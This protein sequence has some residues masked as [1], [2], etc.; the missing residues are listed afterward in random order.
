M[1]RD[2]R[3]AAPLAPPFTPGESPF[4]CSGVVYQGLLAFIENNVT[5]GFERILVELRDPALV[6]FVRQRFHL[7]SAYDIVPLP[8]IGQAI[9]RARGVSYAQQIVDSNRWSVRSRFFDLYRSLV[10]MVSAEALA[11]GLARVASIIQHFGSARVDTAGP[12]H[13]RGTRSGV[14]FVLVEWWI[15]S[16]DAF[17]KAALDR[18]GAPSAHVTFD[19]PRLQGSQAGQ[20]LYTIEFDVTWR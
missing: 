16:T 18:L 15:L 14:P 6:A 5:G 13:L 19:E 10:T 3:F 1:E 12:R 17:L 20:P 11:V 7:A 2:I 4:R 8:Y 9:A